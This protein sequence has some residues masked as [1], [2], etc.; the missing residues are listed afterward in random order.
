M[1]ALLLT[2]TMMTTVITGCGN[3]EK[4][5]EEKSVTEKLTEKSTEEKETKKE[6]TV[7]TKEE[8]RIFTDMLGREVEILQVQLL[9]LESCSFSSF[10][11]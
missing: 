2:V 5:K 7:N 10:Q 11:R 1:I 3:I 9:R 4:K 6:K 8:T